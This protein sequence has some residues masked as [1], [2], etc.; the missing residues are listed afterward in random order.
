MRRVLAF[1]EHREKWWKAMSSSQTGLSLAQLEGNRAYALRQASLQQRR[2]EHF[3]KLWNT[4][5]SRPQEEV[6]REL[7][8]KRR[9][10]SLSLAVVDDDM[11]ELAPS[12]EDIIDEDIIDDD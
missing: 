5:L 1:C 2:R 12:D 11:D 10:K 8:E 6:L 7:E 3:Q 9:K 4:V